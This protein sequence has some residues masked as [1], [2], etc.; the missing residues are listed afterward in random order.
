MV[1]ER[2]QTFADR[3]LHWPVDRSK[4]TRDRLD[5]VSGIRRAHRMV[6]SEPALATVLSVAFDM[7]DEIAEQMRFAVFPYPVTWIEANITKDSQVGIL[8]LED[9]RTYWVTDA[10]FDDEKYIGIAPVIFR[11]HQPWN[12]FDKK[13]FLDR[14]E[15]SEEKLA[16]SSWSITEDYVHIEKMPSSARIYDLIRFHS[17][18]TL[19]TLFGA[20]GET[21]ETAEIIRAAGHLRLIT[22]TL[23]LLNRSSKPAVYTNVPAS[24]RFIRNKLKP[25]VQHTIVSMDLAGQAPLKPLVKSEVHGS[26]KRHH[27]VRHH[28][29]HR[30]RS[31]RCDHD[32]V[33]LAEYP[34]EAESDAGRHCA[35]R[36]SKCDTLRYRVKWHTRGDSL[37]GISVQT[38]EIADSRRG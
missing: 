10:G 22:A 34:A 33:R 17:L 5:I 21:T 38:H 19:P 29:A 3:I 4:E 12:D 2:K 20:G 26:P 8:G 18:E 35:W 30:W 23:L 32:Y 14:Y 28:Y 6:L 24:R 7:P 25:F 1:I 11:L 9:G 13:R 37:R 15:L 36:C 31:R 27:E 16:V